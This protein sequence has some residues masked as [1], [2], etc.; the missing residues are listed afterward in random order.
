[1]A[2]IF[3]ML[4]KQ[5]LLNLQFWE[6]DFLLILW[7]SLL[8]WDQNTRLN[9]SN[10]IALTDDSLLI[11]IFSS[12]MMN[13]VY[14]LLVY[15]IQTKENELNGGI[16]QLL[17]HQP[18]PMCHFLPSVITICRSFICLWQ[19]PFI[20]WYSSYRNLHT[21]LRICWLRAQRIESVL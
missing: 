5:F 19:S 7:K 15:W 13:S 16:S 8:P 21:L 18:P 6:L 11:F 10:H 20:Q 2:W 14:A 9:N 12:I 3:I 4:R 1:M 17:F